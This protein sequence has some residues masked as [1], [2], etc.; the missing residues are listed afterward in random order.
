MSDSSHQKS[1]ETITLGGG[2]FWCLEPLFDNLKGVVDVV[3][4]YSGGHARNPSYAQ[5]CTG[6]T[7]HAEVIQVTFDPQVIALHD[8]L[9]VFFTMHDP[10]TL[11]RQGA[12]VGTQYRSVIFYRDAQQKRVAEEV[13]AEIKAQRLW[14]NP[15]VTELAPFD[16]FY[17]AEDYHQEYYR[18]NPN[19]GYCRVVI[20]PKVSKFRK[21]F[22]ERLKS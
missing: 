9:V 11:N 22:A 14:N 20:D 1:F 15:I 6:T 4:G 21:K 3:S 2:C 19:Q 12:D 13:I 17:E 18:K 16:A 7:G 10:T 5:V 8:L